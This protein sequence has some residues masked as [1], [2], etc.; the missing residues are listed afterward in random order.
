MQ[1][2]WGENL[3]RL[4][5][6]TFH[7]KAYGRVQEKRAIEIKLEIKVDLKVESVEVEVERQ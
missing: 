6:N 7:R 4:D 5:I 3:R 1:N 2:R